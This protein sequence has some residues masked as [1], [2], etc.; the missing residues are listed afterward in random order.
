M[1]RVDLL[2]G[3]PFTLMPACCPFAGVAAQ[4]CSPH[5]V[6]VGDGPTVLQL[7]A[8]VGASAHGVGPLQGPVDGLPADGALV[9]GVGLVS[10]VHLPGEVAP[11]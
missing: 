6:D 4:V 8:V 3:L 11:A 10:G 5:Q 7:D 2:L 1:Q 9:A